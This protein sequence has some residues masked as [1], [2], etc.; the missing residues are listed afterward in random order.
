VQ[1]VTNAPDDGETVKIKN[2][3]NRQYVARIPRDIFE[4]AK[5]Q[6]PR[7]R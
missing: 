2:S 6:A 5:R 3:P 7:A 1:A 4:G